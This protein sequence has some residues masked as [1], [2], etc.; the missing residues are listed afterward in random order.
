MIDIVI[1]T[2][3]LVH[4]ND[5]NCVYY[6]S[7]VEL[8]SRM[9]A[10]STCATVDEGFELDEGRNRSYIGLEYLTH[11]QPGT[12]GFSLIVHLAT[13]DR[14]NF[15]SNTIPVQ[16]KRYIEQLI[17]NK[18]DRMFLRV[19]FNSGEKTLASHD[20]TDYQEAKRKTIR[21]DLG[22]NVVTAEEIN[23]ML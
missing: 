15:V 12:L 5:P 16:R 23:D 9:L 6:P 10:N 2:C 20:Y 18:K 21:N 7:S 13:N 11:L 1:D 3:T 8:I 19:A 22:V 14:I 4:A 17:K